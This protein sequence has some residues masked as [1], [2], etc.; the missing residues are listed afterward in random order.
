MNTQERLP[1]STNR[2]TSSRI[3]STLVGLLGFLALVVLSCA[4]LDLPQDVPTCDDSS[5]CRDGAYCATA[6]L[7]GKPVSSCH[8]P[9]DPAGDS[10]ECPKGE[11]C[12]DFARDPDRGFCSSRCTDNAECG[13]GFVC[14]H[15]SGACECSSDA[16]CDERL[17]AWAGESFACHNGSCT[18]ACSTD[19]DCSCGSICEEGA[20]QRG[21]RA[22]G[23]CCGSSSCQDGRC[24]APSPG[25]DGSRCYESGDC[26]SELCVSTAYARGLCVPKVV[27]HCKVDGCPKGTACDSVYVPSLDRMIGVCAPG[28][29]ADADCREG[30]ACRPSETASGGPEKRVCRPTCDTNSVCGPSGRCRST[31][32]TCTCASDSWCKTY[33]KLAFCDA[34]TKSCTC[35]PD[36]AGKECGDDGCGGQCGKCS[37]GYECGEG[38]KCVGSCGTS[39]PYTVCSDGSYCPP[40]STCTGGK[41]TCAPGY[42]AKDCEGTCKSCSLKWTCELCTPSCSER[43][44][45]GDGCGGSCGSCPSGTYCSAGVCKASG[46]GGGGG[47]GGDCPSGCPAGTTCVINQGCVATC[48]SNSNCPSGCCTSLTNGQKVCAAASSC[49]GGGGGGGTTCHDRTSCVT[50]RVS[51]PTGPNHCAGKMLGWL[52]NNCSVPVYC[53]YCLGLDCNNSTTIPAGTERGGELNGKWACGQAAGASMR[54]LCADPTD[55]A[56]CT[57]F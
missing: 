15:E 17:G 9:C 28:C 13:D 56:K 40:N 21:C 8:P 10:S 1:F 33:G 2:Q 34:G 19:L 3:I 53:G 41:C 32:G 49:A 39:T 30:T 4:P 54:Y 57:Q 29:N 50:A 14:D 26:T 16:A 43:E 35:T 38:G 44:C 47:G 52:K 45:G 55:H 24:S 27:D 42:V 7:A 37:K 25:P 48:T 6:P 11:F 20:C 31:T 5:E 23:D 22:D 12:A 46:G 18:R 36:C 51:Y